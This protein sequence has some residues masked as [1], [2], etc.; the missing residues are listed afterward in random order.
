MNQ[1]GV[2]HH[3]PSQVLRNF[4]EIRFIRIKLPSNELGIVDGVLLKW[5]ADFESTLDNCVILGASSVINNVHL[6]V[7]E[8]GNDGFC[9]YSNTI[10]GSNVGIE[11]D[12]GSIMESFYT[13]RG[14]KLGCLED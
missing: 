12:N 3:S 10:G 6:Q 13:S 14:L 2:T 5:R 4:K 7:S 8:F 9:N 1:G 11:D